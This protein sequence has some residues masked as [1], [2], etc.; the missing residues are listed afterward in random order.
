[1]QRYS[2]EGSAPCFIN[3]ESS[4]LG[5][6]IPNAPH[7]T[8]GSEPIYRTVAPVLATTLGKLLPFELSMPNYL[9]LDSNGQKQGPVNDQQLKALVVQGIITPETPLATDTGHRGKAGQIPGLFATAPSPFVQPAQ[10]AQHVAVPV[11]AKGKNSLI[12]LVG[13]LA[14]L[15]VGGIGWA[16]MSATSSVRFTVAEQRE[17]DSFLAQ[18]GG[19]FK[20]NV[21]AADKD[22]TTLLH[23]AA[24]NRDL[25]AVKYCVSKGANV[26]AT[27]KWGS[28]PLHFATKTGDGAIEII[29]FLVS[30]NA[31]VHSKNNEGNTP[32]DIARAESATA[33]NYSEIVQYLSDV[34]GTSSPTEQV[35][36]Q[37][38]FTAAEQRKFTAEERAEIEWFCADRGNDVK[39]IYEHGTTLLHIAASQEYPAVVKYLVSKGANVN[40]KNEH[41]YTPLHGAVRWGENF[42]IVK[43]LVSEGANVN[44]KNNEGKTPL[45][46]AQEEGN[47]A[48]FEYLVSVKGKLGTGIVPSTDQVKQMASQKQCSN[49]ILQ[50]ILALHTRADM[51]KETYLPPLYTVDKNGKPLHSWRVLILPY[52][53]QGDLYQKI[54]LNEPWDSEHNKQFHS[55][56]PS[57]YQCPSN[58]AKG[59]C[60]AGIIGEV[61]VPAVREMGNTG[62]TLT[63]QRKGTSNQITIVEVKKPFCW[64]DPTADITLDELAKGFDGDG[65][66]GSFHG[67]ICLVGFFDGSVRAI[68]KTVNRETLRN[69]GKAD[70]TSGFSL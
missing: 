19:E 9:Y 34:S 29:K 56:V 47:V 33:S 43:Y 17:I 44:T 38:Q 36:S 60:Y 59:C 37:I 41:G 66:C 4:A 52:I 50:L 28:T 7:L 22:G 8:V 55:Q 63:F 31:D 6:E 58:P 3:G 15:I 45:D 35:A 21:K 32:L 68:P 18:Y 54:R 67:D 16:I 64:M 20:N 53:E 13:I 26:N 57:L 30:K 5:I 27:N 39:A 42:E 62:R 69:L 49:K 51:Y 25:A 14:L 24:H 11:E 61:F 12:T 65:R 1:M 10:A 2:R 48:T 23:I 40:A 46:V 70:A